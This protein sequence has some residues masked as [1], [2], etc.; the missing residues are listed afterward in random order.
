MI[1]EVSELLIRPVRDEAEADDRRPLRGGRA[2]A[3]AAT[4]L[5]AVDDG[6]VVGTVTY[7]RHGERYAEV[8]RPGEAEFRMLGVAP[9]AQ[10]RGI[11]RALVQAC[12]DRASAEGCTALVMCTDVHMETAQGL[13]ERLGFRRAPERDWVPTDIITLI[14]YELALPAQPAPAR[15]R[16]PGP[17]GAARPCGRAGCSR[18]PCR[19]PS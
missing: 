17:G 18:R 15:V 13:Y 11:G 7:V 4:L 1:R 12:I 19:R 3:R 16:R 6:E 5:V 2:R 14:G 8:S 10:G 9:G